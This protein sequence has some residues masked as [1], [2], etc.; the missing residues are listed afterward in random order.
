[1]QIDDSRAEKESGGRIR[2]REL[3]IRNDRREDLGISDF[4]FVRR[5]EEPISFEF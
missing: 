4:E 2:K 1:L 5:G 3:G